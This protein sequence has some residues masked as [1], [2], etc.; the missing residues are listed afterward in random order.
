MPIRPREKELGSQILQVWFIDLF[1]VCLFVCLPVACNA[2]CCWLRGLI[3]SAIR[4]ALTCLM[5]ARRWREMWRWGL[6]DR[7]CRY[8][9]WF[10]SYG[11][12]GQCRPK[13]P[14]RVRDGTPGRLRFSCILFS[15]DCL[16][17]H[18][19]LLLDILISPQ[20]ICW[21]LTI[22]PCTALLVN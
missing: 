17:W 18:L 11:V 12:W 3:A 5:G 22:L 10:F 21:S 20:M 6:K 9:S 4:D 7:K 14:I 8:G 2:Y 15:P 16:S 1:S 13:P 19:K